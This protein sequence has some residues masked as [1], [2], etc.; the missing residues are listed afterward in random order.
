VAH[1]YEHLAEAAFEMMERNLSAAIPDRAEDA[2]TA[3]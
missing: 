1:I 3:A 2:L